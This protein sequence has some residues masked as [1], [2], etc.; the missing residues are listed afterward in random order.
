M[1]E[2]H[3]A[4][5]ALERADSFLTA[6]PVAHN[7][8]LT[9]L[10]HSAA[11]ALAGSYWLVEDGPDVIGFALES[12]P[13]RGVV[14][15]PMPAGASR[16]LA[17]RI[18][19]PLPSVVGEAGTAAAFAGHWTDC[20]STAVTAIDGQRLYELTAVQPVAPAPGTFRTAG[21][22]DRSTLLDWT[23]AFVTELDLHPEDAEAV[24]DARLATGQFWIWDHDGPAA[25]AAAAIPTFGVAR[26]QYVY[27]PPARRARA[28]RPRVSRPRAACSSS[29]VCGAC[30]S[31]RS[32]TRPRTRSTA[33]SATRRSWRS[34]ATTSPDASSARR[35]VPR[36]RPRR[37]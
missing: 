36:R 33:G 15:S 35:R 24:V 34:S 29:A 4:R 9:I 8:L 30:S 21:R 28:T 7:L 32:R 10:Q 19:R 11:H 26:V 5:I 18:A 13:G 23:K 27:T 3:D 31:P 37:R 16:L 1:V 17:E 12:P 6:Q 25:M 2:L 14:L 20:H 22:D